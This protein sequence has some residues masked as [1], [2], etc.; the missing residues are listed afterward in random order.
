MGSV[1]ERSEWEQAAD[2]RARNLALQTLSPC[3][4]WRHGLLGKVCLESVG[5]DSLL[6]ETPVPSIPPRNETS[7]VPHKRNTMVGKGTNLEQADAAQ[8]ASN[9]AKQKGFW[10]GHSHRLT[11]F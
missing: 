9:G 10:R 8:T 7:N 4:T 3:Q 2:S 11:G 5:S 6:S 1:T